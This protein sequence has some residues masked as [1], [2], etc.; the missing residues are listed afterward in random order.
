MPQYST[1]TDT[2]RRKVHVD[3]SQEAPP[4]SLQSLRVVDIGNTICA[5]SRS[6]IVFHSYVYLH[7]YSMES[8]QYL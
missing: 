4:I 5:L 2:A 6:E 1:I 3:V 7:Y 8:A